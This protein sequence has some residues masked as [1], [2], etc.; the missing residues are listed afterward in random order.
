MLYVWNLG[1]GDIYQL[2]IFSHV[3]LAMQLP[4]VVIPLFRIES[5]ISIMGTHKISHFV[6]VLAHL[7][8]FCMVNLNILLVLDM[9][10]GDGK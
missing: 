7:S 10:F 9:S 5:S 8:F 6:K 3:M 2:L 1:S 4:T